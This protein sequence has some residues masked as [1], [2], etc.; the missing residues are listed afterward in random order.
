[1][2]PRANCS[3]YAKFRAQIISG[4]LWWGPLIPIPI[5]NKK[6]TMMGA[7]RKKA[8][9][10]RGGYYYR[11]TKTKKKKKTAKSKEQDE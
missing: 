1:M 2:R 5:F 7:E 9:L 8:K 6:T 4:V 11:R 3:T 10:H